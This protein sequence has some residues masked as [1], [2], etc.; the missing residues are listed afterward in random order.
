MAFDILSESTSIV[1]T[2]RSLSARSTPEGAVAK[3][4]YYG[5]ASGG[6]NQLP[7]AAERAFTPLRLSPLHTPGRLVHDAP[8]NYLSPRTAVALVLCRQPYARNANA[9]QL[10]VARSHQA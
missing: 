2:P 3:A 5:L 10:F 8:Q 9:P 1:S 4:R 6:A 7:A